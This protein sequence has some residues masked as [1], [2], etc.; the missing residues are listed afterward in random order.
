MEAPRNIAVQVI[1][2]SYL[3]FPTPSF[4]YIFLEN[5]HTPP[6]HHL[7]LRSPSIQKAICY[8]AGWLSCCALCIIMSWLKAT[9]EL[10]AVSMPSTAEITLTKDYT[11]TSGGEFLLAKMN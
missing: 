1:F 8:S 7:L 5:K 9:K 10:P 4:P 11:Y 3:H 6:H 2:F